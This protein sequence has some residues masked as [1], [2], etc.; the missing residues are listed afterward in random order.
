[1]DDVYSPALAVALVAA[2]IALFIAVDLRLAILP[3]RRNWSPRLQRAAR[4]VAGVASL[5]LS[6]ALVSHWLLGHPAGSERA[7]SSLAFVTEHPMVVGVAV[8]IVVALVLVRNK[9]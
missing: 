5:A 3:I 2:V 6:L 9:E 7:M 4:S 1:M 8:M